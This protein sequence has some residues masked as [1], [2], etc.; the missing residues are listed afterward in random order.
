MIFKCKMCGG[1]IEPIVAMNIDKCLYYKSLMTLQDSDNEKITNLYNCA[2]ELRQS[3]EFNQALG[4]YGSILNLGNDQLEAHEGLLLCKYGVEY[5]DDLKI[6]EKNDGRTKNSVLSQEI[7]N[8]LTKLNYEVL[9]FRITLEDKIDTEYEQ[10]IFNGLNSAKVMLV[11][12]TNKKNINS[13]WIKNEWNRYLDIIKKDRSNFLIHCFLDMNPNELP[14][15]FS[16]FQ[17]HDLNK[18]WSLQALIR[19]VTK[20]VQVSKAKSV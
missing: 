9:F 17:G 18:K 2:S 12:E 15:K 3:N 8:E 10:Y 6:D 11:V 20:L 19:E 7:Y 5:M 14:E 1:D 16:L 4:L 13:I